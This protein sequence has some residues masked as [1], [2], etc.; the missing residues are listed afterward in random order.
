[1]PNR[2]AGVRGKGILICPKYALV[3]GTFRGSENIR[4]WLVLGCRVTLVGPGAW[5]S[6][7]G[8]GMD[9]FLLRVLVRLLLL[10]LLLLLLS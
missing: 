10:V 8:M 3:R 2:L 7:H 9:G 1:M 6:M 5:G 4:G